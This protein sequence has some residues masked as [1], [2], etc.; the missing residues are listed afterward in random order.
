MLWEV[1]IIGSFWF[2]IITLGWFCLLVYLIEEERGTVGTVFVILGIAGL[3]CFSD[4]NIVGWLWKNP[5]YVGIGVVGYVVIGALWGLLKFRLFA[6]D[7]REKY[8]EA[9]EHWLESHSLKQTAR[10]LRTRAGRQEIADARRVQLNRWASACEA[11]A[12]AGGGTLTD[13]LKPAWTQYR[14]DRRRHWEENE[15]D[16]MPVEIPHPK[17]HKARIMRWIGHWPWSMFWTILND[18]LRRIGKAIY[19]RMTVILVAIG[20]KAFQGVEDDFVIEE[21]NTGNDPTDTGVSGSP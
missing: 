10:D 17:D 1:L 13:A 7:K 14:A 16:Q 2:W 20:Q 5:L 11:A 4:F 21:N 3:Q 12:N 18:P 6:S 19:K 15:T 8:D 9:K